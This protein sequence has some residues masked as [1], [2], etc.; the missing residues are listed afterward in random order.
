MYGV[1]ICLKILTSRLTGHVIP[2]VLIM[3]YQC[4]YKCNYAGKY[5]KHQTTADF[6]ANIWGIFS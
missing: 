5:V 1:F 4:K 2:K 6:L 3:V